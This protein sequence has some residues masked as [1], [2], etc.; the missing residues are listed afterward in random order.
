MLTKSSLAI[1]LS[2][3]KTFEEPSIK[4]EQYSTD[5][6]IAAELLW[7]AF[8]K[9]DIDNKVIA[10][11]GCGTG[12]LGIG[13]LLL[14]AKKVY[15]VDNDNKALEILKSNIKNINNIN[16]KN[17]IDNKN[18]IIIKNLDI[19]NFDNKVDTVIQNPPFGTK[20][21][22]ADK[23]FLEKAF[24]VAKIVYS[25]HKST[26]ENFINK[27]SK[28]NNFIITNKFNFS[29]PLKQTMKYHKKR[30]QRIEVSCWRLKKR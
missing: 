18:R 6:E 20:Q 28:D 10:D 26:S 27:I 23:F 1:K 14:D 22:H 12:I 7:F 15:F 21:E 5:S 4:A 9:G 29:F 8:M 19:K 25:F 13:C 30:I 2:K 24:Q 3:L 16:D 11:L 17:Q